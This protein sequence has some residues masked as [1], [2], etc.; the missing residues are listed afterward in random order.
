LDDPGLGSFRKDDPLGVTLE[1]LDDAANE[2]HGWTMAE[3][4]TPDKDGLGSVRETKNPR[5]QVF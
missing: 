4:P 1:L 3:P 2:T 5:L